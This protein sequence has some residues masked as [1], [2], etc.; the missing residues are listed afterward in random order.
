MAVSID[1][2]AADRDEGV[3]RWAPIG[4][5]GEVDGLVERLVGRLDVGPVEDHDL[6]AVLPDLLGDREGWPVSAT[7]GSVTSSTRRAPYVVRSWP[8]SSDAPGPNLSAGAA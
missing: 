5:A 2:P 3:E 7:P 8:I 1:E 6:D 4:V